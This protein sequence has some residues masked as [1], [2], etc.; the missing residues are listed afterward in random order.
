MNRWLVVALVGLGVVG[1]RGGGGSGS[2]ASSNTDGGARDL[3]Q[4]PPDQTVNLDQAVTPPDFSGVDLS[5]VDLA[6]A[7]ADLTAPPGDM[8]KPPSDLTGAIQTTINAIDTGAVPSEGPSAT[9]VYY[10]QDVILT[11]LGR[12]RGVSGTRCDYEAFV[13]DP[14]GPAPSGINLYQAKTGVV[15][16]GGT[17]FCPF[18]PNSGTFFDNLQLGDK[19]TIVG[20]LSGSSFALPDGGGQGPVQHQIRVT[21][22]TKTGTGTVTPVVITDGSIFVKYASGY[23]TYEDMLVTIQPATAGTL[24]NLD[25][26]RVGEFDFGGGHFEGRYRFFYGSSGDAGTFPVNNST[27]TSITGI[28]QPSF[29]GG[30]SPRIRTDFVP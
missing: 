9:T 22:L 3:A 19:V 23:V 11:G 29:G 18:P 8:A 2:D 4:T 12:V 26:A 30:I 27:F 15:Q 24:T 28:A 17:T 21:N 14:A 16:D 7:P 13:Q 25:V 6:V 10:V 1:C 20:V 5:G